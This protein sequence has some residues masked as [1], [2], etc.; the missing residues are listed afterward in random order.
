MIRPMSVEVAYDHYRQLSNNTRKLQKADRKRIWRKVLWS[1]TDGRCAYCGQ[2]TP[3][4]RRTV[5]HVI[6]RALG[7]S[8]H[9]SNLMPACA[10][11]NHHK[12]NE[13]APALYCKDLLLFF[14]VLA[15]EVMA[16]KHFVDKRSK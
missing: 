9:V 15:K 3:E 16:H 4:D 6:P 11:C 8:C 13:V 14:Y 7:G 12:P 1:E 5:E 2:H 10:A